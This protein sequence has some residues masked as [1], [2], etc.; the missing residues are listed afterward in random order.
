MW[1]PC[2]SGHYSY[3]HSLFVGCMLLGNFYHKKVY[4]LYKE[5][6]KR[7]IIENFITSMWWK[8]ILEKFVKE[9]V[10]HIFVIDYILSQILWWIVF[11][12]NF[13]LKKKRDFFW[14][15][16]DNN[17]GVGFMFITNVFNFK[18]I[19]NFLERKRLEFSWL[20]ND[21]NFYDKLISI[22]D[23]L[24]RKFITKF[25]KFVTKVCP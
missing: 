9:T 10:S 2:V 23:V 22:N 6:Y 18:F 12:H 20:I 16:S 8:N 13:F 19:T 24:N 17:F 3:L 14:F 25:N 21:R 15:I 11:Y 7:F 1:S 4:F 5:I